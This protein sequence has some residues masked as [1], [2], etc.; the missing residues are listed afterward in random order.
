MLRALRARTDPG[1][2]DL[3][4][5]LMLLAA[6]QVSIWAGTT[7]EGAKPLTVPI[8]VVATAGL[9][10]R[11]RQ[12]ALVAGVV[13]VV[14]LV[15]AIAGRS[16]S[17]TWELIVLL[18]YA[19]SLGAYQ[20]LRPALVCGAGFL[21][22]LW[23]VVA[24]DPTQEGSGRLFTAPVL[25]GLPWLAGIAMRRYARQAGR[26]S[27]LNRELER[28]RREDVAAATREE[29]AR[30]ARELHD[31]V[32]H[33][34]SVIVVQ[35]GAAQEVLGRDP[36][37]AKEPLEAIRRTGKGAI[38]E[39]RRLLGILRTDGDRLSLEPQPGIADLPALV[40]EMGNAGL[41]VRLAVAEELPPLPPGPD[42]V[43]YRVVQESLTNA[44]KHAGQV[45]V[46][47]AVDFRERAMQIVV[48]NSLT[49]PA[50]ASGT[51]HGLIG[52]RERLALYGGSVVT[53]P[54]EGR[55]VVHARLPVDADATP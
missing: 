43:A 54:R 30:I 24:L 53:G 36:E 22:L 37:R 8:A 31:V 5:A 23:V 18:L 11:R 1:A 6:A 19:Y 39:M 26:L 3:A 27:D 34:L 4:L 50:T 15:Q 38:A 40:D 41:D 42:L 7:D 14:W 33:S 13:A 35:A 28:R 44:L 12:P 29:R 55:W 51:G 52:M 2:V 46:D 32:A 17:A 10:W 47:V 48:S 16:P 9:A 20:D 49:R 21:A 25:V 45:G